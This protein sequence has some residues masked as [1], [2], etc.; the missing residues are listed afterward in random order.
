MNRVKSF[1][2]IEFFFQVP[3]DEQDID[4]LKAVKLPYYCVC[5]YY[6]KAAGE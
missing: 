6:T 4:P 3:T 1:N 5:K 2:I